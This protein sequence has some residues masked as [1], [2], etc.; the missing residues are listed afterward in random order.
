MIVAEQ[1]QKSMEGKHPDL[2]GHVVPGPTSLTPGNA[3]G[4]HHISKRSR[5]IGGERQDIG[6]HVLATKLAVELL[7]A[8]VRHQGN[9]N[10]TA[11]FGRRHATQ[12]P[13]DGVCRSTGAYHLHAEAGRHTSP[14]L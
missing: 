4:N 2:G 1:V 9:S 10:S 13:R 8:P 7:D 3:T 5:L 6:G 12:P 14:P 11:R